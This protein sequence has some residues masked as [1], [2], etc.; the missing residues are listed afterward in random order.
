VER[1]VVT[2]DIRCSSIPNWVGSS[3]IRHLTLV[4]GSLTLRTPEI[5]NA[6]G[7][8]VDELVWTRS[9]H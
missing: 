2:H 8:E 5:V 6:D 4:D 9:T 1:D 7:T 3:Q